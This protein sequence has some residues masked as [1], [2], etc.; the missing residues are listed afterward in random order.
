LSYPK[1]LQIYLDSVCNLKCRFCLY[2][3]RTDIPKTFDVNNIVKLKSFIQHAKTIVISACGEPLL[4]PHLAEVLEYIYTLNH[5]KELIAIT[6]N[7]TLLSPATYN[8]LKGHLADLTISLNAGT[9]E[10]YNRD[11]VGG[12]WKVTLKTISRFMDQVSSVDSSK[13]TVH[14]VAHS[15]NY[16]EIPQ[17][18][19]VAEHLGIPKLRVDQVMVADKS[20]MGLSLLNVA[21]SYKRIVQDNPRIIFGTEINRRKCVSPFEEFHVWADG[22][23]APCCYNGSMFMGNAYETRTEEVWSGVEYTNLRRHPAK[24]CLTCPKLVYFDDPDYHI[25]PSLREEMDAQVNL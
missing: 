23:V 7:G 6:T 4:S 11:M 20:Q 25:Y 12:D 1:I 8:L 19:E 16:T 5:R 15:E 9:K 3:N 10:T 14:M 22:R 2:Q 24:Q 13:I 21:E 18:F 17:L